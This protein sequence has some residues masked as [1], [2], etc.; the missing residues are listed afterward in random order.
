[1]K[2]IALAAFALVLLLL[3]AAFAQTYSVDTMSVYQSSS[4]TIGSGSA[5]CLATGVSGASTSC[6][7]PL[8]PST[9]YRFEL[10]ISNNDPVNGS[11]GDPDSFDFLGVYA[12]SDVVGSDASISAC[13]CFDDSVHKSGTGSFSGNNAECA[14]PSLDPCQVEKNGG[15]EI[16]FFVL[17]TGSDADSEIGNFL[18]SESGVSDNTSADI[19]FDVC[20]VECDSQLDCDDS[21]SLT[22]DTCTDPGL[23]SATCTDPGLCSASCSNTAC[24]VAC[25]ND[26]TCDDSNSLTTDTCANPGTC[27]AVC[28]NTAVGCT[29]ACSSDAGCDDSNSLTTD[30]CSNPGA[31]D[32]SCSSSLCTFACTVDAD[33]DDSNSLTSDTCTNPSTCD[34]VCSYSSCT[35]ACFI[36]GDCDDFDTATI[37]TCNNPGECDAN[38]SSVVC[39]PTCNNDS[40]CD[41]SDSGTQDTCIHPGKCGAHCEHSSC[42]PDCENDSDCADDDPKTLDKCDGAGSCT[43]SCS[44]NACDIACTSDFD[45]DDSDIKTRDVCEG[46]DTCD[47]SCTHEEK[48]DFS[49]ELVSDLNAVGRGQAFDLNLLVKDLDGNP[50]DNV[51][52]SLTGSGGETIDFNSLGNG[53]YLGTYVV[54]ADSAVG[55]QT[56]SFFASSGAL[57]GVEEFSF[58]ISQGNI[59]AVLVSPV[60]PVAILGEKLELRFKLVYDNNTLVQDGNATAVL[61]D[62]NIPLSMDGNGLFVGHYLFSESDLEGA[63]LVVTA[64]DS[65]GNEGTTSIIFDVRQPLP[66]ELIAVVLALLAALFIASYGLWKTHRLSSLLSKLGGLKVSAKKTGLQRSVAK[67]KKQL[68]ALE[69]KI[70]KQENEMKLVK[71]EIKL[72]RKKQ[73]ISQ[74]RFDCLPFSWQGRENA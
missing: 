14:L 6:I 13:G 66:L 25:A 24:S 16:F 15:D 28:E 71:K 73:A 68:A 9:S 23:C 31:C 27:S 67:E 41:D 55:L 19:S 70:A 65:L 61:N 46:P 69:K 74:N 62:V 48:Q 38:C 17:T 60:E 22:T 42:S 53:Y 26:A 29:P 40:D 4:T 32:A 18:I 59:T 2:T 63:I 49:F 72:E 20:D 35:P 54:P 1:M 36:N 12:A 57:V 39:T 33:C 34:A 3:P 56:L 50:V 58:E 43:A 45:C 37:D 47:A 30:T 7:N 5:V 10:T 64:S 44:N 21:N 11:H 51:N 52:L 8:S